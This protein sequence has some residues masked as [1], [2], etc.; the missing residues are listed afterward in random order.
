MDQNKKDKE[1]RQRFRLS[2]FREKKR[3]P[4]MSIVSHFVDDKKSPATE[5]LKKYFRNLLF[6][7]SG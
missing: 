1:L 6:Y 7:D 4:D 3:I 2:T 5:K